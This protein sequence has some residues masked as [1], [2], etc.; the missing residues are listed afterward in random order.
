[1]KKHKKYKIPYVNLSKQFQDEKE[2]LLREIEKVLLSGR[3]IL[4]EEVEKF[5][6]N[7]CKYLNVKYCVGVNSGTDALIL[8]LRALNIGVGDEVIT[9]AN[10]YI[11][12][13]AAIDAVGAKPVFVDVLDDQTIDS[14]KLE[15]AINSRTKAIIPVH[16]TGRMC[17]M[18][19]I[20][21]IAKKYKLKVIE[22][23]AQSFGSKYNN[24][25]SAYYGDCSAFSTHPLKN[26]NASGDGGFITTNK[27]SIFNFVKLKRNHGHIDRNKIKFWGGVSRL[28]SIQAVILNCRIKKIKDVLSKREKN[29]KLYLKNLDK[30]F[31]YHPKYRKNCKDTY[32]LF[33][34]QVKK[35]DKLRKYLFENKI[36]TNIHYPVPIHKQSFFIKRYKAFRLPNTE[37]QAKKILS[38]PINQH[39]KKSEILKICKFFNNFYKN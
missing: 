16:I 39:L 22:D 20:N 8:S 35:R 17:E 2:E 13:A 33:V 34:I 9:Q 10:S 7:I 14:S 18:D 37:R 6:K 5:E 30:R 24:R 19:K 28:D 15:S 21:I 11:A 1:M 3:Y 12:T 4:S 23:S 31:F 38:L 32:H 29:A 36:E 26:F 25:N 27:K